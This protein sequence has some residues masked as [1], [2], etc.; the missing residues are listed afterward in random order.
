MN[1]G[2][3]G[4]KMNKKYELTEESKVLTD[5]STKVHRIKALKDFGDVKKGDLG[6]FIEKEENLSHDGNCWVY[7]EAIV[8]NYAQ[9]RDNAK[10]KDNALVCDFSHI[11]QVFERSSI[12]GNAVI[13][14]YA[15][16]S[17]S[18]VF[19]NAMVTDDAMIINSYVLGNSCVHDRGTV[20]GKSSISG[21][22][23][24]NGNADVSN[25]KI[26][27][28]AA[29]SCSLRDAYVI[30]DALISSQKDYMQITASNGAT[31]YA[32]RCKDGDIKVHFKNSIS[33]ALKDVT[34]SYEKILPHIVRLNSEALTSLFA[35]VRNYF[36]A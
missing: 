14:G 28:D 18:F 27:M 6:G 16:V 7:D 31:I 17:H 5:Y 34:E 13:S 3:A 1:L 9:I 29:V 19:E 25:C 15:I 2:K 10:I 26:F 23:I 4:L 22:A 33:V 36:K 8:T 21:N 20:S 35:Y 30:N 12:A 11:A 24:V 32:Y